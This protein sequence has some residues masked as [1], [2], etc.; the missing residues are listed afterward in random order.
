V[1][2]SFSFSFT[3]TPA[4]AAN[5]ASAEAMLAVLREAEGLTYDADFEGN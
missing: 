4:L 3:P 2:F 5:A 1:T